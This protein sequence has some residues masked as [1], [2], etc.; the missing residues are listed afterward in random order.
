MG[1]RLHELGHADDVLTK[2]ATSSQPLSEVSD[3][4]KGEGLENALKAF[5]QHHEGGFFEKEAL[6][7]L[8]SGGKLGLGALGAGALALGAGQK[9]MAGDIPGGLMDAGA[10]ID[11][12]GIAGAASTIRDRLKLNP[13]D[14]AQ[15]TTQDRL[16]ALP[17]GLDTEDSAIQQNE[18]TPDKFDKLK[19]LL[20]K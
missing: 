15:A 19:Q 9:A 7:K 3:T 12:T 6:Q 20:G 5:G 8:L 1:T 11:P 16:S 18:D 14:A 13:D 4:L 10:M 17:I 2:G